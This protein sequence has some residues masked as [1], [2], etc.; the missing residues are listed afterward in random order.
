MDAALDALICGI[1]YPQL[2][3]PMECEL[4]LDFIFNLQF[5]DLKFN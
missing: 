3:T 1:S 5:R 4:F 2:M